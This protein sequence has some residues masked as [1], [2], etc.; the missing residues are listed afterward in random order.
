MA[1]REVHYWSE[2]SSPKIRKMIQQG[3]VAVL[4]VGSCEQHGL[5]LPLGTDSFLCNSV[6]IQAAKL[7]KSEP[8]ILPP[9]T[10][11][12]SPHH[13]DF[14]GTVTLSQNTLRSLIGDIVVSLVKHGISKMI[15]VNGHGGNTPALQE[16]VN[17]VGE[18]HQMDMI[19]LRYMDMVAPQIDSLRESPL[20]GMGHAC[21]FETSLMQYLM[22]HLVDEELMKSQVIKGLPIYNPDLFARNAIYIYRNFR[23]FS[24]IGVIGD[25]TLA[26]KEKG[27]RLFEDICQEL[28]K[29]I[30]YVATH[31]VNFEE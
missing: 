18:E 15:I 12:Y 4:P 31:G 2:L 29:I 20:G 7:A 14:S 25:P 27:K 16:A 24:K 8:I 30:D 26:S 13:M 6:V 28:S 23:E 3:P 17:Q 9:I 22:P 19:L 11:G 21:E 5:H 10:Y 1:S